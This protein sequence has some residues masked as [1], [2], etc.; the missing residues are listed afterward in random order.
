VTRRLLR[1]GLVASVALV[2][3]AALAVWGVGRS[4]D[5]AVT[6]IFGG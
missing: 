2:A 3:G 5:R 4:I 6:Q 1:L